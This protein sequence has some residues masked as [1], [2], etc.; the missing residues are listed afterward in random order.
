MNNA[1]KETI[2]NVIR[3]LR[4][5]PNPRHT[6]AFGEPS[7]GEAEEVRMA[8][9]GSADPHNILPEGKRVALEARYPKAYDARIYLNTWVIGALECLLDEEDGGTG[10]DLKLAVDLSR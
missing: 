5:E 2:R 6:A 1:E 8:L 10:R 9:T 3:R 4:C 7:Y